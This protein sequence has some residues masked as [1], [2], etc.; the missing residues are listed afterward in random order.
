VTVTSLAYGLSTAWQ[1]RVVHGITTAV[2]L[3]G[4][5]WSKFNLVQHNSAWTQLNS[6]S[7]FSWTKIMNDVG[8]TRPNRRDSETLHFSGSA[9][10]FNNWRL[11]ITKSEVTKIFANSYIYH[12]LTWQVLNTRFAKKNCEPVTEFTEQRR[13][14]NTFGAESF[15]RWR[16]RRVWQIFQQYDQLCR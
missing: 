10:F 9:T 3:N 15:P 1:I 5:S 7:R 4:I 6:W 12:Q 16:L 2:Q 14:V 13:R 8:A 11:G